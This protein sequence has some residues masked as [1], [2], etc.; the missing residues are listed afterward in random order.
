M[1]IGRFTTCR[2][3]SEVPQRF[4]HVC[5]NVFSEDPVVEPRGF[6]VIDTETTG[7]GAKAR[8][9]EIG[10]VFLSPR[11]TF[12]D[13]FSTLVYGDGNSGEWSAKRKHGI[14]NEDLLGAP[15]F[16]ELV[17]QFF[18]AIKG[19]VLSAHNASFESA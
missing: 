11:S 1:K 4:F 18:E 3:Y 19:W 8:L 16:K 12:Q 6:V 2:C 15:K 17:P 13:E 7:G 14:R 5:D 10:M 9:I